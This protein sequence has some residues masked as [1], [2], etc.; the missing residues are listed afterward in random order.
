MNMVS[1]QERTISRWLK[2]FRME[3]RDSTYT[4]SRLPSRPTRPRQVWGIEQQVIGLVSR[5][6]G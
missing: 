1:R 5:S 6:L 2:E 4:V 3:C